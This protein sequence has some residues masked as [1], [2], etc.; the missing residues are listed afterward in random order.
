MTL[1]S[2]AF[3]TEASLVLTTQ[4]RCVQGPSG[5]AASA[6]PIYDVLRP[7]ADTQ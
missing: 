6:I 7:K 3:I 5:D 2:I 4:P 1:G